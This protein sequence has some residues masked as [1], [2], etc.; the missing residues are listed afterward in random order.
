MKTMLSTV[1][2]AAGLSLF[3]VQAQAD[4]GVPL[5]QLAPGTVFAFNSTFQGGSTTTVT[6]KRMEGV[7]IHQEQENSTGTKLTNENVG[8]GATLG[9]SER[10]SDDEREKVAQLF[11]LKVGNTA[12]S[13]HSGSGN[14]GV[15][16]TQD[17]LEVTATE[18]MTVPAGTFET[19]VIQTSMRNSNWYGNNTC[20]YAPEIGYCVKRRWASSSTSYTW[21]LASVTAP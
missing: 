16:S 7:T 12:N 18:Q 9:S 21:E 13:S 2:V 10:M 5:K 1:A 19:F 17:K 14:F 3:A 15:W 11:P 8:F 20:W 4:E 6:I